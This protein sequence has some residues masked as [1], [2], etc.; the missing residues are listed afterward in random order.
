MDKIAIFYHTCQLP[1]WQ[2]LFKE[3]IDYLESSG[4]LDAA[5]FVNIGINGDVIPEFNRKNVAYKINE[6]QDREEYETLNWLKIFAE[7]NPD[8]KIL[9]FHMKG[10]TRLDRNNIVLWRKMMEYYCIGK[11]K[12]AVDL[13]NNYDIVGTNWVENTYVGRYPHFSG[14]FWWANSN[15]IKTLDHSYLEK[16]DMFFDNQNRIWKEFWIGTGKDKKV[17]S[18]HN[19]PVDQQVVEYPEIFWN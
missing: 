13:L 8:Y 19:C 4:L 3:Q 5:E 10:L 15:Y 14:N 11:W 17:Y 7:E 9:Y 6:R 18:F 12:E 1:G 16:E 2:N